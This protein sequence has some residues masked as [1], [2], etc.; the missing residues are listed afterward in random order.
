MGEFVR[1]DNR[2]QLLVLPARRGGG[3]LQAVV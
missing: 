2:Q 1:D 3:V